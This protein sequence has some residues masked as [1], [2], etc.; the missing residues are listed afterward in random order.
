MSKYT[1]FFEAAGG[2]LY[3]HTGSAAITGSHHVTG[4]VD[5]AY[6][7]PGPNAWSSGGPLGTPRT[8]LGGAGTQ[9]AALAFGGQTPTATAAT[10][11][12]NSGTWSPASSMNTQRSALGGAG[13]QAAALAF[14][15]TTGTITNA[16]EEYSSG[17]W[18]NTAPAI[19]TMGIARESLMAA[20]TQTAALAFGGGLPGIT[21]FTEQYNSGTWSPAS[22]IWWT[23]P[24]SYRRHRRVQQWNLE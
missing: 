20:G 3:P 13:T 5:F 6:Q 4:S 14:G 15:G 11:Q 12:Y 17:A 2:G 23:R 10:E 9:G 19:N 21:N 24:R 18:S 16:T 22:S 7:V 8:G 1:D